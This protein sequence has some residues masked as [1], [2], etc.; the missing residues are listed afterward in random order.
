MAPASLESGVSAGRL[1][2]VVSALAGEAMLTG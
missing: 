2:K 1:L